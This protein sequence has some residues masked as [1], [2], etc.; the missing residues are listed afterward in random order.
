VAS[1]GLHETFGFVE[2]GVHRRIGY[3]NG[4]WHDVHLSQVELS[5][6]SVDP[7]RPV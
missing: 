4:A 1:I 3:K 5:P 2:V 6:P 7:R